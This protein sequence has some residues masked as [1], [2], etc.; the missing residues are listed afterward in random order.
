MVWTH[1]S[2]ITY[3]PKKEK[4]N[5]QSP[6]MSKTETNLAFTCAVPKN[7]RFVIWRTYQ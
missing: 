4:E 2:D 1:G 6:I 7:L 3:T 5:P